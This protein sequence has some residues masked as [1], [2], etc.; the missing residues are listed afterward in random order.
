MLGR[1]GARTADDPAGVD[2]VITM[3]AGVL[4]FVVPRQAE[5][6]FEITPA[7]PLYHLC[8]VLTSG[9]QHTRVGKLPLDRMPCTMRC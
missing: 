4:H 7:L 3:L 2:V 6:P 5:H 8:S 9:A 1:G